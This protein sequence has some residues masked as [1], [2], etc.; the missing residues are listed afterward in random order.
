[1]VSEKSGKSQGNLLPIIC[2]NP[3]YD[4]KAIKRPMTLEIVNVLSLY[5]CVHVTIFLVLSG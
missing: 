5:I 2:G 4:L 1:M 3:D